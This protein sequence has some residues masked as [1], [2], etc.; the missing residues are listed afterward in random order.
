MNARTILADRMQ[1]VLIPLAVLFAHVKKIILEMHLKDV[2][3]SIILIYYQIDDY[4]LYI[5]D[6]TLN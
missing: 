5:F 1:F 4:K 2:L 6:L 3:V